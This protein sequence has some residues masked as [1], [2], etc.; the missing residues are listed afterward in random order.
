MGRRES[1]A[2]AKMS[3]SGKD[4][5]N[6]L[7]KLPADARA[8][9]EKIRKTI[10]AVVPDATE[11]IN[12]GIPMFKHRGRNLVGFGATKNHCALYVMSPEVMTAHAAELEP[13]AMGKGSIRFPANEP[14]PASLVKKLVK[15]RIAENEAGR[16]G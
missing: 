2:D 4:V 1:R 13:Y 14:P 8:T 9:L 12:Y 3:P 16:S 10:R 7:A 6:F 15:A 11:T 5:D